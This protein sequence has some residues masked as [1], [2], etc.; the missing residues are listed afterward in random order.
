MT[1][2]KQTP[3]ESPS[4][5]VPETVI[6]AEDVENAAEDDFSEEDSTDDFGAVITGEP[7]TEGQCTVTIS[8][9]I[10][11]NDGHAK[12]P[13]VTVTG[14]SHGKPAPSLKIVR[15]QDIGTLPQV[16]TE[17]ITKVNAHLGILEAQIA[18]Q[19]TKKAAEA[20]KAKENSPKAKKAKAAKEKKEKEALKKKQAKEKAAAKIKAEKERAE[21]RK[22]AEK[23]KADRA[24]LAEEKKAK[25][26]QNIRHDQVLVENNEPPLQADMFKILDKQTGGIKK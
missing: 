7:Y 15:L 9:V 24:K 6:K 3:E 4:T 10:H 8:M 19:K 5:V 22:I 1:D 12:G 20:K 25:K 23:L 2:E 17:T 13:L 21:K 26:N 11:P 14:S 16:I 18:E